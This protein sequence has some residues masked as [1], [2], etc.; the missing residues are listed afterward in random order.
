MLKIWYLTPKHWGYGCHNE[1][2][3]VAATP[4]EAKSL[5]LAMADDESR[6]MEGFTS[7]PD[8]ITVSDWGI[9]ERGV[10]FAAGN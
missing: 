10:L 4:E 5:A 6:M 9:P 1:I 8:D 7:Q 3:V 2:L